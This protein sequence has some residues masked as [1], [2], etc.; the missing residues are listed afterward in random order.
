MN[1]NYY[2]D[3]NHTLRKYLTRMRIGSDVDMVTK[4]VSGHY[5][6]SPWKFL[7]VSGFLPILTQETTFLEDFSTN[8]KVDYN[9]SVCYADVV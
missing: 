8:I 5:M 9:I 6:E 4:S 3:Y 7:R 1:N 2:Y